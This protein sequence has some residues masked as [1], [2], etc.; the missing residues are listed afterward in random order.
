MNIY[1]D[2]ETTGLGNEHRVCEIAIVDENETVLLNTLV[3]PLRPISEEAK[4]VH[5]ITDEMVLYSPTLDMLARQIAD[6]LKANTTFIYNSEFDVAMLGRSSH[7]LNLLLHDLV[8]TD[9]KIQCLMLDFAYIYGAWSTKRKAYRWQP[10]D[11]A[12]EY[13]DIE[14]P[15]PSHRALAD[16]ISACRIH[17][18]MF[19][20]KTITSDEFKALLQLKK[21]RRVWKKFDLSLLNDN[22]F[23]FDSQYIY[24]NGRGKRVLEAFATKGWYCDAEI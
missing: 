1:L 16:A 13:Y 21:R 22:W 4:R 9:D 23:G 24:L 7:A 18:A 14:A 11:C 15:E 12:L 2:T 5:G 19:A 6:I 8:Q 10:L 17:K 20:R 3:N